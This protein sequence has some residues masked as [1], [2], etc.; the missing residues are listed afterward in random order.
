MNIWHKMSIVSRFYFVT[1][2]LLAVIALIGG[3][4]FWQSQKLTEQLDYIGKFSMDELSRLSVVETELVELEGNIAHFTSETWREVSGH[5]LTHVQFSKTEVVGIDK[6]HSELHLHWVIPDSF[7]QDFKNL[8]SMMELHDELRSVQA[9]QIQQYKLISSQVRRFIYT[10]NATDRALNNSKTVENLSD[11]LDS[12]IANTDKVLDSTNLEVVNTL[13]ANNKELSLEIGNI[14]N[15]LSSRTDNLSHSG[16]AL[17][18]SLLAHITN[19]KGVTD[20]H[21]QIIRLFEKERMMTEN[22]SHSVREQINVLDAF[23]DV[24]ITEAQNKVLQVKDQQ[25]QYML[26]LVVFIIAVGFLSLSVVITTSRHIQA[27]LKALSEVLNAM[28]NRDLTLQTIYSESKELAW[29]AKNVESVRELQCGLLGQLQQ[30]SNALNDVVEHNSVHV[31]QTEQAVK[32]QVELTDEVAL[33]TEEM[34]G[35]INHVAQQA[36]ATNDKMSLAVE[37]SQKG[38][39]HIKLNDKC[40]SSTSVLLEQTVSTIEHLVNDAKH[41]ESALTMIEEIAARTNLLALNA[42]IEAARA[43]QHGQGFAVVADEVCQLATN[44]TQSTNGILGNIQSLQHSVSESVKLIQQCKASMVEAT[45]SSQISYDAVKEVKLCIDTA[46]EMSHAISVAT[47]QQ[48]T[49]SQIMVEKLAAIKISAQSNSSRVE[50]LSD[51]VLEIKQVSSK[52]RIL[53]SD[54]VI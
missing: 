28:A 22:M 23:K 34:E 27:G 17:V 51:S 1:S 15:E 4:G 50:A 33:L 54:F 7:E 52:Q 14:I 36:K 48:L 6:E 16:F 18:N 25:N 29:L 45:H 5:V 8:M 46:A 35:V 19:N 47:A 40:I 42:A 44:T 12:L 30:S 39:E 41:I 2:L 9:R 49:T 3:T 21:L 32:N 26:R 13:L 43:G 38:Y 20:N 37:E 24:L 11:L 53:V 10:L 31:R